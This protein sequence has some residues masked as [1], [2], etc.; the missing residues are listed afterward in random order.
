MFLYSAI[1]VA[2]VAVSLATS[3][4]SWAHVVYP[5]PEVWNYGLPFA[6]REVLIYPSQTV[7]TGYFGL[8]FSIDV[9]FY[10]AAGYLVVFPY[11]RRHRTMKMVSRGVALSTTYV[12]LV[13]LISI[14]LYLTYCDPVFRQWAETCYAIS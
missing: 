5:P 6:W 1:V 14:S 13:P 12:V 10:M 7:S 3:L 11:R 4:L 2:S 9:L 8:P